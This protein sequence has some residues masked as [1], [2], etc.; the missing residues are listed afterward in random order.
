M[1]EIWT[2][3]SY[4]SAHIRHVTKAAALVGSTLFRLVNSTDRM[5]INSSGDKLTYG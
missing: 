1:P 4:L 3:N 2:G 5:V